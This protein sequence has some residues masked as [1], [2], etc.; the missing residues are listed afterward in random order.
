MF[1][2]ISD[3]V[4]DEFRSNNARF[5]LQLGETNEV[6]NCTYVLLYCRYIHAV[7]LKERILDV[8]KSRDD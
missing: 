1:C 3:H 4:A 6:S 2:D 5:T 8:R 7:G